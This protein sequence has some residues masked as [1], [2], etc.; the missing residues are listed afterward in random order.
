MMDHIDWI[1][2]LQ[3]ATMRAFA[4]WKKSRKHRDYIRYVR[5]SNCSL[6]AYERHRKIILRSQPVSPEANA[7]VAVASK[8]YLK[9]T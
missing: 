6:R 8:Q 7:L 4:T 1:L 9:V 2:R 5:S 3:D